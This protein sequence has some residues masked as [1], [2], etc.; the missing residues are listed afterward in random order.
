[1][2][3]SLVVR[4]YA[5][6]T[7]QKVDQPSLDRAQVSGSVFDWLCGLDAERDGGKAL[8][9]LVGRDTLKLSSYVG[10][11][12]SPCGQ[13]I[14]VLPKHHDDGDDVGRARALLVK[15]INASLNLPSR[16]LD[17]A[18]LELYQGPLSEWVMAR[19]LDELDRLFKR[20]L[21]FDYLRVEEEQ[22]YLRGQLDVARQL[23]QPA[24]KQHLFQIRHDVFL[25]DRPENR[26]LKSALDLVV[27]R[28]QRADNWRL[29]HELAGLLHELPP[30]RDVSRDFA[31]WRNDRLMAHYR[32]IRPWC[33]LILS[34]HLPQAVH[35]GWR[36]ISFLFP[37]E[38]LFEDYVAGW[39]GR[40]L[41]PGARLRTQARTHSLC[42]H[43]GQ[44]MFELRPDLLLEHE[45]QIWVLDTKWK[46][47]DAE[48]G[49]NKYGL[50]Q[51]D[52]YQMFAYG[53]HYQ[54]GKGEM[55]LIYPSRGDFQASLAPFEMQ[56]GKLRLWVLPFDLES[57]ELGLPGKLA[58]TAWPLQSQP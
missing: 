42:Q 44:T 50:S 39:L 34:Q 16:E 26:L 43:E 52:F 12:E 6:L 36:G 13:V 11:L 30:S 55:A 14:E 5:R 32:A 47:L 38:R 49:K 1:M 56:Q 45:G 25:P 21:R 40:R 22:R 35:G 28:C 48:K 58:D 8:V 17:E 51:G 57:D 2:N 24:H 29:S 3:Q 31:L 7:T 20:G 41:R 33:E 4:E 15:L 54:D 19:F 9:S 18:G 27:K 46:R 10:V 37:M 23:R 53:H